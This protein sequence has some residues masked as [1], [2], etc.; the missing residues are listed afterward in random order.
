[1][2]YASPRYLALL[3]LTSLPACS[4][5]CFGKSGPMPGKETIRTVGC[6]EKGITDWIYQVLI[7]VMTENQE[8]PT[9]V[10]DLMSRRAHSATKVP[11]SLVALL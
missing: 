10:Q 2:N 5:Y 6:R 4:T 8:T 3:S 1:M 9:P 7:N 11:E